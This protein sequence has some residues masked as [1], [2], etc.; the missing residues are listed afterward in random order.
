[1][2]TALYALALTI[3][4][5]VPCSAADQPQASKP[6]DAATIA[7]LQKKLAGVRPDFEEWATNSQEYYDTPVEDRFAW[8]EQRVQDMSETFNLLT[9][10]DAITIHTVVS[11]SEYSYTKKAFSVDLFNKRSIY[12]YVYMKRRYGVIPHKIEDYRSLKIPPSLADEVWDET[13]EGRHAH[14]HLKLLPHEADKE[15]VR[16]GNK[17]YYLLMTEVDK[18]ELWSEDETRMIWDGNSQRDALRRFLM[19]LYQ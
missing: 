6:T 10:G 4:L 7:M 11:L 5:A 12:P 15:P 13:D 18:V 9:A 1:M 16:I 2:R 8:K 3:L 14:V 19:K 17:T